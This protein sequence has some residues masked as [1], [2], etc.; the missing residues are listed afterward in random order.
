MTKRIIAVIVSMVGIGVA[1]YLS[2]LH[3][4]IYEDYQGLIACACFVG[5]CSAYFLVQ[6]IMKIKK[7]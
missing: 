5:F 6:N 3:G 2:Y 7:E 1:I 4:T